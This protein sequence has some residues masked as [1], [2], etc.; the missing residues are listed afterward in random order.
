MA[1]KGADSSERYLG[2]V[3]WFNN[4]AGFGFV[5]CLNGDRKDD[6]VFCSSY[7]CKCC[8]GAI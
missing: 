5:T 7:R 8:V 1:T 6:D 4:K 2:R 3:K